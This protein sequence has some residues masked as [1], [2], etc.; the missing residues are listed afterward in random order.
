MQSTKELRFWD[1][2]YMPPIISQLGEKDYKESELCKDVTNL[3]HG[4]TELSIKPHAFAGDCI[5]VLFQW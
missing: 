1:A 3:V 2:P 4:N 5:L